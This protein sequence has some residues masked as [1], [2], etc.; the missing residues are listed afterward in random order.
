MPGMMSALLSVSSA[1]LRL[2]IVSLRALGLGLLTALL[3]AAA[4]VVALTATASDHGS[5]VVLGEAA[6]LFT[7]F[8]GVGEQESVGVVAAEGSRF[9]MGD[10]RR[11]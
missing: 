5:S 3:P 10:E 11:K 1:P 2:M 7:F 9:L 4:A 6:L 8:L